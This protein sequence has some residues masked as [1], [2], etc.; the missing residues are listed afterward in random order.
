M[1]EVF[2]SDVSK[3]NSDIS[4]YKDKVSD[5]RY[6]KALSYKNEADRLLSIGAELLLADYLGRIPNYKID[7]FGK[8]YGECVEFNFS[9]S[10]NVAVCAVSDRPVGADIE[11]IRDV[12]LQI[13]KKKFC[14]NEYETIIKSENPQNAFFEYW[15]K[16]ESYVKALGK[17]MRIPFDSFDA[18]EIK[19]WKFE[20]KKTEEYIICVCKKDK[21]L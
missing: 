8:P 13:A 11:K 7:E 6:Q 19:G 1:T 15:V 16:K 17:G 4:V 10:G 20:L 9:H 5:Y 14:A 3:L 2:I 12:N 21:S 18:D